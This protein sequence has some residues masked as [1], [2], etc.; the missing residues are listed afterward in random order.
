VDLLSYVSVDKFEA[1]GLDVLKAILMARGMKC[2]GTLQQRAERLWAVR[3]V[4]KDQI[5][6]S[7][8]ARPQKGKGRKR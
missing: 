1:L 8:L 6:S 7:L 5:D 2:G 3:G 4:P